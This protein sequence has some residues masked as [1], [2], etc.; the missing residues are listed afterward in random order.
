MNPD[1]AHPSSRR[2]ALGIA[3]L[4]T[5]TLCFALLDTTSQYVG[6]AV[7]VVMAVWL[8]YLTQTLMTTALLWPQRGR[9]LLHTHAPGWQLFRGVLMMGSSVIAY[10]ALR[11]V[12]VGEFTA[13]M[14]LVPL[15]VTLLAAWMLRERVSA[16]TWALVAGGLTGALIVVRPKGSDFHGAMLLPLLLV[17]INA[18]YQILTSRM[19]RTEDPGTMHFYTGL[20]GLACCSLLLPW[21]WAPMADAKLWA[22]AGLLGVFGSIGHYLLIQAYHHAPASRL[23]PYLYAQIAFATLAGWM[24]FG[25]APD[26][27]TVAGIGLIALC[28]WLGTRLRSG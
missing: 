4:V 3:L 7:P 25:H 22:L 10:M 6:P 15:A 5:A 26:A 23:T 14:M 28:G 20:L 12:P 9:S 8:R 16:L 13:I 2:T 18:S 17:F 11:H 27:W 24:V 19:V 1:P 21:G